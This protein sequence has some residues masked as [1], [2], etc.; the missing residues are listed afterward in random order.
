N[1]TGQFANNTSWRFFETQTNEEIYE[2]DQIEG[3]RTVDFTGV[4]IGDVNYSSDPASG[5]RNMRGRLNLNVADKELKGGEVYRVEVRSDNFEQIRGLQYT[6]DYADAYVTL[7]S[8]EGGALNIT[9]DN[10]LKYG[11]GTVTFR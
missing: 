8:I 1:P 6:L 2:F 3:D 11:P 4:K 5:S 7:E 10:Y 9:G